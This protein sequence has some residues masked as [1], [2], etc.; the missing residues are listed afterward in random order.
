MLLCAGM[1]GNVQPC[2]CRQP[3]MLFCLFHSHVPVPVHP[4]CLKQSTPTQVPSH[5]QYI[6]KM[7]CLAAKRQAKG[8]RL[9]LNGK[10]NDRQV[11]EGGGGG[12]RKC[13]CVQAGDRWQAGRRKTQGG[14]EAG[15]CGGVLHA[16]SGGKGKKKARTACL[17]ARGEGEGCCKV[18]KPRVG[19]NDSRRVVRAGGSGGGRGG[20][21]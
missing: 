8:K 13:V 18:H 1:Y 19:K 21:W 5:V 12:R 4:N 15:R 11:G 7:P 20:S 3:A 14:A 6:P 2:M 16:G 17:H 9:T 10:E